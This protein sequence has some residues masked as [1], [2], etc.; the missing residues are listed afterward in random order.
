MIPAGRSIDYDGDAMWVWTYHC[1]ECGHLGEMY[2]PRPQ[3]R[4]FGC[5][6]C[7]SLRLWLEG[8]DPGEGQQELF[9]KSGT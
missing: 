1:E 9:G 6:I 4:R 5:E 2:S 8:G 3:P 7:G